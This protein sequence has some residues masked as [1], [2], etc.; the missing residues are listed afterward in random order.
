M[1]LSLSVL[2]ALV[3]ILLAAGTGLVLGGMIIFNITFYH[4]ARLEFKSLLVIVFL[5]LFVIGG[6]VLI[7]DLLVS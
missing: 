4:F 6:I 3:V 7:V 5:T 2:F 1:E